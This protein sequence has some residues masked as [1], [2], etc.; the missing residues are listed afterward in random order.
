MDILNYKYVKVDEEDKLL[1]CEI[2]WELCS[3][4]YCLSTV[5]LHTKQASLCM[6]SGLLTVWR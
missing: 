4:Y 6:C 3:N 5:K 1:Y 2:K